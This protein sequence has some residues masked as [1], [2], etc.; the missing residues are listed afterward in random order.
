MKQNEKIEIPAETRLTGKHNNRVLRRDKKVP[1][2]VYGP[3]IGNIPFVT[4]E[5]VINRYLGQA[6]DNTIFTLT[7]S[8]SKL[9]KVAVMYKGKDIHPLTRKLTHVDFYALDMTKTIRVH[10]ELRF[11]G[12]AKG[13][14]DGGHQQAIARDIE[15]ECLPTAIPEFFEVDTSDLGVHESLH[16]S[17]VKLP[18]GVKLITDSTVTLVTVTII[19]EEEIVTPVAGAVAAEPEVIGKG[20]KEEGEEGAAAPAAGGDK[21]ADAKPAA[22]KE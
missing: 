19:K 22:K 10:V 13:L 12:K 2:V 1:G 5:K 9:N 14:A 15:V 21:K 11:V 6:H 18:D 16:A 7:S 3:K 20:K 4:E 17:D 8:D